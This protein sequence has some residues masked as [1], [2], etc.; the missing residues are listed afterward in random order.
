[1]V[2]GQIRTNKVTDERLIEALLSVPREAFVPQA[3]RGVAYVDE[4][5]SIGHSR[6]MMEPLVLA[7]LI[8]VAEVRSGDVVL[9]VAPGTGYSTALFGRLASAVVG[10]EPVPEL[11]ATA[12]TTLSELS[13]DNVAIVEGDAVAGY[14]KQAPYDVILI[15]GTVDTLPSAL[16]DQLGEN[17]RLVYVQRDKTGIGRATLARRIGDR[18]EHRA[19]FDANVPAL[20]AFT[21]APAFAL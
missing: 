13:A 8:Q 5:I 14:P 2:N 12:T 21:A 6:Y 18:L 10:V 19:L 16:T 20:E 7:R 9:D 1:M 11:A 17:G 4:D 15:G 3:L